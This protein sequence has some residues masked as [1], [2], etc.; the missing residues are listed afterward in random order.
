MMRRSFRRIEDVEN[1]EAP[2]AQVAVSLEGGLG[3]ILFGHSVIVAERAKLVKSRRQ[4][5]ETM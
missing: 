4:K 5:W 1:P 2:Q 3:V